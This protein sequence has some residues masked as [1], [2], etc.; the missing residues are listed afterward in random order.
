MNRI[1]RLM[2]WALERFGGLYQRGNSG[3]VVHGAVVDGIAV[4]RTPDAEMVEMRGKNDVFV[5]ELWVM[6]RQ[7]ADDV[8]R[9]NGG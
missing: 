9:M 6:T 1:D 7:K 2:G 3:R 5:L 4:D 8:G